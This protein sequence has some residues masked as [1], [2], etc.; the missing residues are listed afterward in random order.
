TETIT[1]MHITQ[2]EQ[3]DVEGARLD[4]LHAK[5]IA[6]YQ[7]ALRHALNA[8]D[9]T[10]RCH[11]VVVT[12]GEQGLTAGEA[13][14]GG[15]ESQAGQRAHGEYPWYANR[16]GRSRSNRSQRRQGNEA[17]GAWQEPSADRLRPLQPF[18]QQ[19]ASCCTRGGL[20]LQLQLIEA[21]LEAAPLRLVQC[22]PGRVG[23]HVGRGFEQRMEDLAA[24]V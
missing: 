6:P 10:G 23:G 2:G 1:G 14:Q 19:P 16:R 13:G 7:Y 20:V 24:A 18:I 21:L 9:A 15:S 5:R 12:A 11:A 22:L 8:F 3:G 17:A 4:Q